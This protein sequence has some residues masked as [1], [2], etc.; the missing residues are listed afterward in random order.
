ML[1]TISV[2]RRE[3][4]VSPFQQIR[5]TVRQIDN[6][7]TGRRPFTA[8]CTLL[9]LMLVS[10]ATQEERHSPSSPQMAIPQEYKIGDFAVGTQAYTFNRFSV[11]EAIE[12]TAA[13]GGKIIELYPGQRLLPDSELRFDHTVDDEVIRQVRQKLEEEGV[14]AVNFG[15]IR[16]TDAE[17][18]REVFEFARKLDLE[19][20]TTNAGT[21]DELDFIE[22]LVEEFDIMMGIH[23]H[24]RRDD[25]P[26]YRI[27]DPAYVADLVRDRDPR[28]GA[29]A[30][31]GHWI[32]SG[33]E[34]VEALRT[35]QG[36][37]ISVHLKDVDRFDRSGSDVIFGTGLG[38]VAGVLAE[39]RRQGFGGHLSIEYE[40][41]WYESVPDV[42]QNVGFIRGWV[43]TLEG[44]E[45]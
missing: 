4:P 45:P 12:K 6:F 22:P 2:R 35:L 11:F 21:A 44:L 39:L 28:I 8:L 3:P 29:C 9:G 25:D 14:R 43:R 27:W 41:N 7:G 16:L 13:A 32:R 40:S 31:T 19:A 38:D 26:D 15:V 23:N 24:P 37:V 17:I 42:A 20:I 5:K 10:C 34:P 30:D 1:F 36:R 33:I 18:A